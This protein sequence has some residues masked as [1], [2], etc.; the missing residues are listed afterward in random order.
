MVVYDRTKLVRFNKDDQNLKIFASEIHAP[1]T[2]ISNLTFTISGSYMEF[3][4]VTSDSDASNSLRLKVPNQFTID[5]SG[6]SGG[7]TINGNLTVSGQALDIKTTEVNITSSQIR[8]AQDV[9]NIEDL[10][11]DA[12]IVVG[13]SNNNLASILYRYDETYR[14]AS[15]VS[16]YWLVSGDFH[17]K[18]DV[19]TSNLNARI[20]TSFN[21]IKYIKNRNVNDSVYAQIP[22]KWYPVESLIT[23]MDNP[24][25]PFSP[26]K[27]TYNINYIASIEANRRI[28]FAV[29]KL[30]K[31]DDIPITTAVSPHPNHFNYDPSYTPGTSSDIQGGNVP[32]NPAT[33]GPPSPSSFHRDTHNYPDPSF[34]NHKQLL[35]LPRLHYVENV[36][37]LMGTGNKGQITISFIDDSLGGRVNKFYYVLLFKIEG[38]INNPSLDMSYGVVCNNKSMNTLTI[39]ELYQPILPSSFPRPDFSIKGNSIIYLQTSNLNWNFPRSEFV[40]ST[41]I[42]LINNIH[43]TLAPELSGNVPALSGFEGTPT[44]TDNSMHSIRYIP[45]GPSNNLIQ[46]TG[47]HYDLSD[48]LIDITNGNEVIGIKKLLKVLLD[49]IA[50][51]TMNIITEEEQAVINTGNLVQLYLADRTTKNRFRDWYNY[52]NDL[53]TTGPPAGRESRLTRI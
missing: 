48:V 35:I 12:G 7:A 25:S 40:L 10:S 28:S 11:Q 43:F 21:T 36:G 23:K 6:N 9:S 46:N 34:I 18:G 5:T 33:H 45:T 15:D 13:T 31:F 17:F 39:Q 22:D 38:S 44:A 20:A 41:S 37:P 26:L 47:V 42:D 29:V 3:K 14:G 50:D 32:Y 53:P 1:N 19:I 49:P 24:M 30:G 27:L 8:L 16:A 4:N 51:Q 2:D 52:H